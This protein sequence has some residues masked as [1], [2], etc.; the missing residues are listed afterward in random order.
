MVLYYLQRVTPPVIPCLQELATPS[1][2]Y[3]DGWLVSYFDFDS[4]DQLDAVSVALYMLGY[5]MDCRCNTIQVWP[6]RGSNTQ[7][8]GALFAGFFE[9][10]SAFDFKKK[11]SALRQYGTLYNDI[12]YPALWLTDVWPD[13]M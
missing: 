1:R 4:L 8:V 6:H 12:I 13:Q 11:V 10:F 7:S 3:V 9:Y 5:V 2:D